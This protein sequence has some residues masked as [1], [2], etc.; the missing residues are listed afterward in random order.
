MVVAYDEELFSTVR[1]IIIDSGFCVLK[2][3]IKLRNKG[4]FACYIIKKR[5]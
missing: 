2:G 5:R 3:L 4:V 1:Y